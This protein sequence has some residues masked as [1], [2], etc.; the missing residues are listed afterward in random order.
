M[1]ILAIIGS[2][3]I[4]VEVA[5]D[6]G[7]LGCG[8]ES[9]FPCFQFVTPNKTCTLLPTITIRHRADRLRRSDQGKQKLL[10]SRCRDVAT[11]KTYRVS[12]SLGTG[13][14]SSQMTALLV[15]GADEGSS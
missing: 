11:F 9:P 12:T 13:E 10:L 7:A 5:A 8:T 15:R 3:A 1:V 4:D 2:R 14:I 6:L